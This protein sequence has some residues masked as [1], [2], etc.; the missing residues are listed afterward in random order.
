MTS[1]EDFDSTDE[2]T[3]RRSLGASNS[4]NGS[5]SSLIQQINELKEKA[6]TDF[7][8]ID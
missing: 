4:L 8:L 5:T 1:F 6:Q 2:L 7:P 3:D